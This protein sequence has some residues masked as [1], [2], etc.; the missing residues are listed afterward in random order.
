MSACQFI[1]CI[2]YSKQ[3]QDQ[4]LVADE[5]SGKFYC[6]DLIGDVFVFV[7]ITSDW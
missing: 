7:V 2:L 6:R 4:S 3:A 5:V 1:D